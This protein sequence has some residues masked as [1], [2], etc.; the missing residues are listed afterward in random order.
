MTPLFLL[1]ALLA[2]PA[3]ANLPPFPRIPL[4]PALPRRTDP[5]GPHPVR[6]AA[7]AAT[8]CTAAVEW[9]DSCLN[10]HPNLY[11]EPISVQESCLCCVSSTYVADVYGACVTYLQENAPGSTSQITGKY[12]LS[13][14][15]HLENFNSF[16]FCSQQFPPYP[17]FALITEEQTSAIPTTILIQKPPMALRLARLPMLFSTDV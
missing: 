12:V 17:S 9:V 10:K 6:Q 15:R 11:N 3:L 4:L 5:V 14:Y 8:Y 7:A 2:S 13:F 1:V 16:F